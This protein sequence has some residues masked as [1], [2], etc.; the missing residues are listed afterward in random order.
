MCVYTRRLFASVSRAS[1]RVNRLDPSHII[2]TRRCGGRAAVA[3]A[4]EDGRNTT[5]RPSLSPPPPPPRTTFENG[6]NV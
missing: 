2:M 4:A 5:C 6:P 3:A 1:L